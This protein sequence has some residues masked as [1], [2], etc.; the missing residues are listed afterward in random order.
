MIHLMSPIPSWLVKR[1]FEKWQASVKFY[2]EFLVGNLEFLV[3][4]WEFPVGRW[5][6]LVKYLEVGYWILIIGY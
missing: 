3:G 2:L 1:T 4:H 6:F 5:K